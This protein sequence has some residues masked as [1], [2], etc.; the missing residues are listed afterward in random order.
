MEQAFHK[1]SK[2][3]S[4]PWCVGAITIINWFIR[5]EII[6]LEQITKSH[7]PA[8]DNNDTSLGDDSHL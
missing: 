8:A 4:I 3:S 7:T 6:L 1:R 2:S 5:T